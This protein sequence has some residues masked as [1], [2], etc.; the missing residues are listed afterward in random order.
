MIISADMA[1][2]IPIA[3][4]SIALIS[5][6]LAI[7][8]SYYYSYAN[9][10]YNQLKYYSISQQMLAVING[11]TANYSADEGTVYGLSRYY[12]ISASILYPSN[13]S[14][15]SKFFCRVVQIG[16]ATRILVIK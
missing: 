7:S 2:A 5:H 13:Y 4:L 11:G 8:Q 6:S 9:S 1:A 14:Y 3:I 10:T 16:G 15:C 12:N